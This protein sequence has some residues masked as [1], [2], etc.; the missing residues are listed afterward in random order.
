MRA[1]RRVRRA[2]FVP[3]ELSGLAYRDEPIPIPHRQVT[4]QPSLIAQMVAALRL[5]G[6]ERVLEVGTGYGFQTAIL[7]TLAREVFSIERFRDLAERARSNL[8]RAGI[9]GVTVVVG[10]GTLGLVEHAPY[11]AIVVSAAAPEIPGP[12]AE[13]LAEGGRMVHPV[14]SGGDEVVI[15]FR[16]T[17]D[18]LL[19]QERLTPA[20]FVRL[21]G[22]HGLAEWT[23][24]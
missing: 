9:E 3:A 8:E 10:D 24:P 14:G 17:G 23:C 16:K 4:T 13:Q 18:R 5:T 6:S 21:I 12:L 15:A 22:A 2:G 7:A 11:D 1:F 20:S 19:E